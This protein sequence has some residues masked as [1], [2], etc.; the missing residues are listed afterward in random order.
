MWMLTGRQRT[1]VVLRLM[2]SVRKTVKTGMSAFAL[3]P[4]ARHFER[5]SQDGVNP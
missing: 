5:L 1:Y 4:V 3:L 2:G